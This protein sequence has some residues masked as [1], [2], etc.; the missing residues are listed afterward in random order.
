VAGAANQ[1]T[2]AVK[3]ELQT[4]RDPVFGCELVVSPLDADGYG[5][6]GRQRAHTAAWERARGPVPK[7]MEIDHLCRVR[8]CRALHHLE[9]VTRSQNELRKAWKR[10]ARATKCPSG[11]EMSTNR[12]V[13]PETGGVVCRKCN[14]EAKGHE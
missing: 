12:V 8:N 1:E 13:I 5:L 9:L 2:E 7:G 4:T 3:R 11:H 14:Q 10:R 6:E